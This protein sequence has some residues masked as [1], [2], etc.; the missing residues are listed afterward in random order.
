MNWLFFTGIVLFML[1]AVL[2]FAAW[3]VRRYFC[4]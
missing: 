3:Y 4:D 2:T 1:G